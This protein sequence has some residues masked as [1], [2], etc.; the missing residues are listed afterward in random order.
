MPNS[1]TNDLIVALATPPGKGALAIVRVSGP[2]CIAVV[3]KAIQSLAN[4]TPDESRRLVYDFICDRNNNPIDEITAIP[5]FAPK[6]YTAEE[7]VEIICHGGFTASRIIIGRLLELGMR[8]ANPGEFTHRAFINGRISLSEAE[9]VAAAIE[10]KSELALKAAARNLKGE[11]K[12]KIGSIKDAIV[13]LLTLLEA[14]IDFSDD[15][16][17][18]TP[19]EQLSADLDIQ[20]LNAGKILQGYDFGRGLNSGYNIVIAGRANVG[21]SSLLNAILKRERAIVTDIPGTTRDTLT[22]GIEI[23]GF[24]IL[25]TDTAGLRHT[26]DPIEAIG[27]KRTWAEIEK[28][29]LLLFV[30]DCVTGMNWEDI[31]NYYSIKE[32][33]ILLV[34]NKIDLC[35]TRSEINYG[36]L[37]HAN[38]VFVSALT[39]SGLEDL[40][41]A[42]SHLLRL[43]TF[44]LDTAILTTER[45]EQA[46]IRAFCALTDAKIALRTEI[47]P[48]VIAVYLREALD[49][50]GELVGETTSEDIL[51]N[52]FGKFCIGK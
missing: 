27:Q 45:Q 10:A 24:P 7:T 30:I 35:H 4:I 16:I 47:K 43:D 22:E 3:S 2:G 25:L 51:N 13:N 11:L 41:E 39:D 31:E 37:E 48:E 38:K 14:E 23:D 9:S 40:R 6:S 5:Y 49:Y 46:M 52:I 20:L 1:N 34:I 50:L 29:D 21:K 44:S 18:K 12:T 36:G 17:D 32:K 42:I 15:E 28:A 8:A 19:Y 33:P 26:T